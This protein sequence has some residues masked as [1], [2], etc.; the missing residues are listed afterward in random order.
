MDTAVALAGLREEVLESMRKEPHRGESL[1]GARS[2][3]CIVVPLPLPLGRITPLVKADDQRSIEGTRATPADE[4]L[5]ALHA[6][7]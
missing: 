1:L 2:V 3:L 6:Y 7:R 5:V 4:K